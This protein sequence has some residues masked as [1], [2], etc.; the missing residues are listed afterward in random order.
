MATS[1]NIDLKQSFMIKDGGPFSNAWKIAAGIGG[2][3]L[4]LS[5]VGAASDMT[6]FAYAYVFAFFAF[7]T[8]ALGAAFFV[9]IQRLTSAGW[10]VTVRRT[11]EFFSYG[12]IAMVVLAIP[13][14]ANLNR[15]CPMLAGHGEGHGGEHAS[16]VIGDAHAADLPPG[17]PPSTSAAAAHGAPSADHAAPA[18]HADA[19]AAHGAAAAAHGSDPAA[20][21][22]A[23]GHE[24]HDPNHVAHEDMLEKKS[25][26]FAKNFFYGRAAFYLIVWIALAVVFFN[27]SVKQDKTK[28]PNL[29]LEAQKFAPIGTMFFALSLTFA[30]F[31]W[32]MALEPAWF[33]TIFGVYVFATSV[34][35]SL[36]VIILVTMALRD[37]GYLKDVVTIEHYHDLGKLLF[38]FN[39][40]WAYIGFSQFMLIWYAA[41]PEETIFYHMRWATTDFATVHWVWPYLSLVLVFGHFIFPF[42]L[43][44]SR[45]SKRTHVG[46]LKFGAGW[47]LAMHVVEWYWLVLPNLK[48]KFNFHWVDVTCLM[49]VGGI[50]FAFVMHRMTKHP[51]IPVGDPRLQRSIHFMNA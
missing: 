41:L 35:S 20:A 23:G 14:I 17:T 47:L 4:V 24:G 32:V 46:R 36:A 13:V 51:L 8:I 22:H 5:G 7:L 37:A 15:L 1:K 25:P 11:A 31:D 39:V 43:L 28:D 19:P 30:A 21:A 48:G 45:H 29:T 27:Y 42:L 12:L 26:W 9:L 18:A 34:V 50:Y 2:V 33:S 38:G 6:R 44:L 40:F 3:G 49:A 10:S 16:L